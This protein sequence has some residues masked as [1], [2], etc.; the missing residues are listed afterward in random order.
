MGSLVTQVR[1]ILGSLK[2]LGSQETQDCNGVTV[3][4]RRYRVSGGTRMKGSLEVQE[5]RDHTRHGH[6]KI[7]G[8]LEA[9]ECKG[10]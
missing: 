7:Y 1:F 10:L 6:A 3:V 2:M 9:Q 4:H 5:S 8:F